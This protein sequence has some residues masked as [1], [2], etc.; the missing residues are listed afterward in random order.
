MPRVNATAKKFFDE[1][2]GKD[3]YEIL[4]G[5]DAYGKNWDSRKVVD[6]IIRSDR[7]DAHQGVGKNGYCDLRDEEFWAAKRAGAPVIAAQPH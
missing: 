4:T 2:A 7:R 1:A 5:A 3:R 6:S